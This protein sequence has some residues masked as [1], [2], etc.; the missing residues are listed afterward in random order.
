[1]WV[2]KTEEEIIN[3]VTSRALEEGPNFDAKREL[4]GN[5]Q[6]I[7]KDIAAMA[8]DGGVLIYGIGEDEHGRVTVLNPIPLA[9]QA[10]RITSIVQTSV[11]EPPMISITG[12]LSR[13][14]LSLGYLI[15]VVPPS[16]RAPH[17]VV[18]RGD[19]RYY[20]R[21]ATGN[22][23]LTEGE[24]ARLYER[25]RQWEVDR[26][27]LIMREVENAPLPRRP[28]FA[29]LHLVAQPT[30]RSERFLDRT[31]RTGQTMQGLLNDLVALVKGAN[32]FPPIYSPDFDVPGQWI[33]RAEGLLGELHGSIRD[34]DPRAP[35][36]LLNLQIDFDGTGHLFCGRAAEQEAGA[37]LF[38]PSLV[39]G[40]TTRF[41]ALLG[42]LFNRANFMGMV[43]LGVALT[44]LRGSVPHERNIR[45]SLSFAPYDRDD[46][47]RTDRVSAIMLKD[48]PHEVARN[49]LMRLFTAMSQGQIDPFP[50]ATAS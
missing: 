9:G 40:N 17:M 41:L 16:V 3:A 13:T 15:V 11:S 34:N 1:M 5:N 45:I 4:P 28:G 20:G 25:R 2:P 19:N 24:V 8:N 23:I 36:Y 31:L 46:Y 29:Y 47:K 33:H 49:L 21:T 14:D 18:V 7:A 39:A 48:N 27:A 22:A 50:R 37:L 44:G 42:E 43:D 35:A 12:I 10:E 6:E 38:F 30:Y 26:E 32:I